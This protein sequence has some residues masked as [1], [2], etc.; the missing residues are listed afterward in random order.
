LESLEEIVLLSSYTWTGA[1]MNGEYADSKNWSSTDGGTSYPNSPNDTA[2]LGSATG[3]IKYENSGPNAV[4]GVVG[5]LTAPTTFTGDLSLRK[6]LQV[7]TAFSWGNGTLDFNVAANTL[8]LSNGAG[9]NWQGGTIG[10]QDS[11][12][13][14]KVDNGSILTISPRTGVT[15]VTLGV[16]LVIGGD[17][18]TTKVLVGNLNVNMPTTSTVTTT[19]NAG[20]T[21][22][23]GGISAT[24]GPASAVNGDYI[25]GVGGNITFDSMGGWTVNTAMWNTGATVWFQ[26]RAFTT[27]AMGSTATNSRSYYQAGGTTILGTSGSGLGTTLTCSQG[28]LQDGGSFQTYSTASSILRVGTTAPTLAYFTGGTIKV[29]ADLTGDS[30]GY[31]QVNGTLEISGTTAV[32]ISVSS[33]NGNNRTQIE[34]TG[35]FKIDDS[36]GSNQ[37]AVYVTLVGAGG[38]NTWT[39]FYSDNPNQFSGQFATVSNGFKLDNSNGKSD[40]L[41]KV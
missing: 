1:D 6:S 4:S 35:A 14:F 15:S 21:L 7:K 28:F 36:A 37:T 11:L 17:G 10:N 13:T 26:N 19:V 23:F 22:E 31:L 3:T 38:V 18:T 27:L 24:F 25:K 41:T 2:N 12:G 9:N 29:G 5:T 20:G 39:P 33:T 8:E 32:Y 16:P 40:V 30:Y 34:T